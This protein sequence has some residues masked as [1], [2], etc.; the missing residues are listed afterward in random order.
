MRKI[1]KSIQGREQHVEKV[2]WQCTPV[3]KC[4]NGASRNVRFVF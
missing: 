1:K 4:I 2:A 3:M